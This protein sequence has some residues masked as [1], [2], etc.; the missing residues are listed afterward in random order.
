M[1]RRSQC[2]PEAWPAPIWLTRAAGGEV[3]STFPCR[4]GV[5]LRA[6]ETCTPAREEMGLRMNLKPPHWCLVQFPKMAAHLF[7][8]RFG[9]N[10]SKNIWFGD[11]AQEGGR[12]WV[13]LSAERSWGPGEL[14]ASVRSRGCTR[15]CRRAACV[16]HYLG[17]GHVC[18][19]DTVMFWLYICL[20]SKTSHVDL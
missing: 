16:S 10:Y 8:K 14:L 7:R 18:I 6:S 13:K 12:W 9:E 5:V 2:G 1:G 15:G 11:Q 17:G 20:T 3:H 4:L 19:E